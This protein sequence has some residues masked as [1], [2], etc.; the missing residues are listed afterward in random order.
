MPLPGR[1]G[2]CRVAFIPNVSQVWFT[3]TRVCAW[4][5][6]TSRGLTQT[7][8]V[9]LWPQGF[10]HWSLWPCNGCIYD[11]GPCVVDNPWS[12]QI[13]CLDLEPGACIHNEALGRSTVFVCRSCRELVYPV[14]PRIKS[15]E[16]AIFS[17]Y[18]ES[19]TWPHYTWRSW[20]PF[21]ALHGH[22]A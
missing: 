6:N 11:H 4:A 15:V 9:R 8:W 3:K 17:P 12:L 22:A 14:V 1:F 7:W 16:R 19:K 5:S 2:A 21:S 10:G 13:T 18:K 20:T